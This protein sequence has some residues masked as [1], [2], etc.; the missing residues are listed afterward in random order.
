MYQDT[1]QRQVAA[2]NIWWS[3]T[4]TD[5]LVIF[6]YYGFR[7]SMRNWF[8]MVFRNMV[9]Y[10]FLYYW[11]RYPRMVSETVGAW[12]AWLRLRISEFAAGARE[13]T[14]SRFRSSKANMKYL[15]IDGFPL[16][17]IYTWWLSIAI[18]LE[19]H[20]PFI[21][22]V[23]SHAPNAPRPQYIPGAKSG[24]KSPEPVGA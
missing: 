1:G 24:A 6:S 16:G 23:N 10:N 2:S 12:L 4:E 3:H 13:W 11:M 22:R 5:W 14:I 8:Q 17:I 15:E 20:P 7:I 18:L 19:I 21:G 9:Y